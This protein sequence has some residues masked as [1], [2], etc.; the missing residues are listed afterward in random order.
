MRHQIVAGARGVRAVL[1]EAGN[2]TINQPRKVLGHAFV[3]E[4]EFGQAADL[5]VLDQNVGLGRQL[6]DDAAAFVALEIQFDRALAAV[7]SMEIGRAQIAAIGGFHERRAPA[8]GIVAGAL[9]LD[10]DDVGAQVGQGLPGP[11]TGQN[12]GEFEDADTRQ[13]LRHFS[14]TPGLQGTMAGL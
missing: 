5:E 10:L 7:G 8:A 11:G 3:V 2:R 4:A 6:A 14:E 1:A 9:A 13:R 12:T